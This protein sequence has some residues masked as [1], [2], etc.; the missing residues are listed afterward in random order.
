MIMVDQKT[1]DVL[2]EFLNQ[3]DNYLKTLEEINQHRWTPDKKEPD[4]EE[5][6]KMVEQHK[7]NIREHKS[8]AYIGQCCEIIQFLFSN[9]VEQFGED[10]KAEK[11]KCDLVTGILENLDHS[12]GIEIDYTIGGVI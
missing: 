8:R 10:F 6:K 4:D 7:K 11:F 2:I 5:W 1:K 3:A 9:G 12:C